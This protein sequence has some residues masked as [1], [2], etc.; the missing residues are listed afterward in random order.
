MTEQGNRAKTSATQR[1]ANNSYK[2]DSKNFRS[3]LNRMNERVEQSKKKVRG[4]IDYNKVEGLGSEDLR[5]YVISTSG[6][7][8]GR[9]C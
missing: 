5:K 7:R 3:I 4:S 1:T 6:G 8:R 9:I 2:S